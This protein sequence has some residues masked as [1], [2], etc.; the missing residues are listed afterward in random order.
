MCF[1][2]GAPRRRAAVKEEMITLTGRQGDDKCLLSANEAGDKSNGSA[3]AAPA[4][5]NKK[6][7]GWHTQAGP[8]LMRFPLLSLTPN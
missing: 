6:E 4:R 7:D 3:Q 2:A 1:V 5:R 8:A